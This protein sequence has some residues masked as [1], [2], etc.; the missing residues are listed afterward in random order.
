[1][2]NIGKFLMFSKTKQ[3]HITFDYNSCYFE[4]NDHI[5]NKDLI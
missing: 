4:D 5:E 1:M 2:Y 3:S